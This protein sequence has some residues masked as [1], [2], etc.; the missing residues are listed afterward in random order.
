MSNNENINNSSQTN[1]N[2]YTDCKGTG[3][4]S[5]MIFAV[6]VFLLMMLIAHFKGS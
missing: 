6:S 4:L 3:I 2:L 5:T 1:R